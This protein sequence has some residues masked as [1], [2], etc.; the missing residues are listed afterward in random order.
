MSEVNTRAKEQSIKFLAWSAPGLRRGVK[1]DA[2][3]VLI[4]LI[5]QLSRARDFVF[6]LNL[7]FLAV[8]VLPKSSCSR[9]A[10]IALVEYAWKLDGG[11]IG[12]NISPGGVWGA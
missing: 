7:I 9:E 1:G 11:W 10:G 3:R 8:L 2:E 12:C 6:F 4:P 5:E